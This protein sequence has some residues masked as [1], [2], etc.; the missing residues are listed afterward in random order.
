MID[1]LTVFLL[2]HSTFA[3]KR[4]SLLLLLFCVVLGLAVQLPA[5][6]FAAQVGTADM[7]A[8]DMSSTPDCMAAMQKDANHMPCK[9]DMPGCIAMMSSGA[10]IMLADGS[11]PITVSIASERNLRIGISPVLRG[12]SIAP[13]PEPP[14]VLI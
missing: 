11:M 8:S 1:R 10:P 5:Q 3:V 9:C 14:S 13:E 6:A 12:R 7:A 4:A 2:A